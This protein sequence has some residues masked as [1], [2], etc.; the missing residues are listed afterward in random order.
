MR[1]SSLMA[2]Q[3]IG[4]LGCSIELL[5]IISQI[6]RLR[7]WNDLTA[8]P[9]S[10]SKSSAPGRTQNR[11]GLE[12]RLIEMSQ[13]LDLV[14]QTAEDPLRKLH[15]IATAEFYRLAALLYLQHVCPFEDDLILKTQYLRQALDVLGKLEVATSPWP[16]FVVSCEVRTDEDRIVILQTL[17][18]MNARR[19]IG[20]LE[21]LRDI[22][23]LIWK[24]DDLRANYGFGARLD[25]TELVDCEVPV[26]WF[27]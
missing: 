1:E 23:E 6:N 26:P 13:E 14:E 11:Q 10:E 21:A 17:D 22:I 18:Q 4:S 15:I 2:A 19:H 25:W 20:N 5:E 24:Q 12:T 3:I 9:E 27:V 8:G 16:L 7:R